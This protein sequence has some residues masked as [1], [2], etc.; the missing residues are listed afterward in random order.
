MVPVAATLPGIAVLRLVTATPAPDHVMGG[1]VTYLAERLP[2]ALSHVDD[3]SSWDTVPWPGALRDDPLRH[4]WA[5]PGGPADDLAWVHD[6]V[7]VIGPP[8][9]Q[10]TWNLSAIWRIPTDD[11]DAW[12]KCVPPFSRHEAAVLEVLQGRAV[13]RLLAAEG[14]RELLAPMPGE[15]GY[16]STVEQRTALIDELVGLQQFTAE[17]LDVLVARGVPDRRWATLTPLVAGVVERWAPGDADLRWLLDTMEDRV[18]AIETCG[19]PDVL[20]HGDA[21]GGNA[22]VG[23]DAGRG[24]WFDWSDARIG[25]PMLDLEVLEI[26]YVAHQRD[27]LLAHWLEAWRRAVPG[28]DPERA[29]R[30]VRPLTT[31]GDA[32]VFQTFLDGIEADERVYHQDDPPRLLRA[33]AAVAAEERRDGAAFRA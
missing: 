3:A 33:A 22:R 20:V 5:K 32:L 25:H 2:P 13:P 1:T 30:L 31:L 11:G 26:P 23:P 12:L 10:R 8:E 4:P 24:V 28:S 9:Q 29:W 7:R 15:D 21:H 14:H 19:L 16:A 17:H 6:Q 18:A 27:A